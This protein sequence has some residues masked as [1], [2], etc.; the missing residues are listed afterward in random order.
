MTRFRC[1]ADDVTG[2][3]DLAG[4]LVRRGVQVLGV[5]VAPLCHRWSLH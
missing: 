2:A 5:P 4:G 3:A 1:I